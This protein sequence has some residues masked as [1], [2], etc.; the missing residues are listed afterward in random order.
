VLRVV[1][2]AGVLAMAATMWIPRCEAA[3][4][5]TGHSGGT[6][7]GQSCGG[8]GGNTGGWKFTVGSFDLQATALG[9]YDLDS[10][11]LTMSV[12]VG[13][14]NSAGTLLGMVTVPG[15]TSP[16]LIGD[17]RYVDL[18]TPVTLSSG[19]T[20]TL[21]SRCTGMAA[22]GGYSPLD[23]PTF[24]SSSD[25]SAAG[26]RFNNGGLNTVFSEPTMNLGGTIFLG[27]NLAYD[28]LAT[29]SPSITPTTTPTGTS[30]PTATATPTATP[31]PTG[32]EVAGQPCDSPV[33]CRGNLFCVDGVCCDSPCDGPNESCNLSN[34][35]GVCTRPQIAPATSWPAQAFAVGA[36]TLLAWFGLRAMRR[37]S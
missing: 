26:G 7:L 29:P 9:E 32:I 12:E 17:F 36:L 6:Q 2:A 28:V 27:P 37:R 21:G 30:T 35:A 16:T 4:I 3:V 25:F 23:G 24:T 5:V 10:D 13:L 20:Y 22:G 8:A 14:W 33:E 19:Q 15:G 11:G 34:R 18:G 31:T 1:I